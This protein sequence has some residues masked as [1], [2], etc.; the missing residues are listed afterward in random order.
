MVGERKFLTAAI[1]QV[2][3]ALL[4]AVKSG[5]VDS[6]KKL[7][8]CDSSDTCTDNDEHRNTPLTNAV[9]YGH[10]EVVRVLLEGGGNVER[11]DAYRSTALRQAAWIG[12][13]DV[14]RLLLDW[15]AEVDPLSKLRNT[16]LIWAAWEGHLSVL[17]LLVERG[18]DVSLKNVDGD[19][20]SDFAQRE[21]KRDVAEWLDSVS[22][23][24]Q[25]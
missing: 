22:R 1:L 15:G 20:A 6:A 24:K 10:V 12:R 2:C 23:R 25:R 18:A 11:V 19:T 21:G 8:A 5:D 9:I 16:P 14:C 13:L 17:K 7:V 4:V 3:R